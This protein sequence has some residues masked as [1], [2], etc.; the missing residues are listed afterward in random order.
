MRSSTDARG[1][2]AGFLLLEAALA[3]AIIGI[4]AIGVL[5]ATAAQ[6]RTADKAGV[7]VVQRAL[8]EDRI[9]ALRLLGH[10][11]L[12]DLPDSLAAGAF[13]PPFDGHSWTTTVTPVEGEHDLFQVSL[14]L[15]GRG[16]AFLLETLLH[17]P[18]PQVL[19]EGGS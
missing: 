17:R 18:R 12:A 1:D 6:V 13:P 19:V 3:L 14:V 4:V 10:D 16:E 5:G 8:A 15:E 2:R 9:A 7:L 11:R